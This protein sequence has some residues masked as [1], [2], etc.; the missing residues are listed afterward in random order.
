MQ[1][2]WPLSMAV[3]SETRS[4]KEFKL[5]PT[6]YEGRVLGAKR[7]RPFEEIIGSSNEALVK[8]GGFEVN[9]PIDTGSAVRTISEKYYR[10]NLNH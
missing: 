9:S 4:C 10:E 3:H 2:I 6:L 5:Q 1:A 8:I 7:A